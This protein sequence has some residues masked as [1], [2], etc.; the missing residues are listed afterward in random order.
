VSAADVDD[1][2]L[3]AFAIPEG[4]AHPA[5]IAARLMNDPE[6]VHLRE[7]EIRIEYLFRAMP[8]LKGGKAVLG[9][10]HQPTCQG[11]MRPVFEWLLARLFG[12]L[13]DFVIILDQGFWESVPAQTKDALIFHELCHVKQDL[14]QYGVPKFNKQTGRAVYRLV[15]HDIEE[16]R[17]V[18]ERY[19]AWS[20][21]VADFVASVNRSGL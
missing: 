14:D 18:V 5:I 12:Y 8:K 6:H 2:I 4:A 7:N 17:A 16:F 1:E 15:G 9:S 21:D 10:V 3:S 11:E 13:P 19:G 20:P